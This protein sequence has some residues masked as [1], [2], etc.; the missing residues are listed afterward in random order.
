MFVNSISFCESVSPNSTSARQTSRVKRD[1]GVPVMCA[2][3]AVWLI[4]GSTYLAIKV[5]LET[6][7]PFAMQGFR[8]AIAGGLLYAFLRLR[9]TPAPTARQWRSATGVGALLLIGGIGLVSVAED[10]GIGTGLVATLIAIQPMMM[11]LFGGWLGAWPRRREWLGMGVGLVGVLILMADSG[12]SGSLAGV[13]LVMAASVS[14]SF[15][16]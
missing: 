10:W 13:G 3:A 9:G 4:W 5:G 11:S 12:L 16:S 8:F 2:L 6:I 7:P 15:G 1:L 14:W